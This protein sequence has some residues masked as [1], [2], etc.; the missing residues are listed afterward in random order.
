MAQPHIGVSETEFVR[1]SNN[2]FFLFGDNMDD[3]D[4]ENHV[5]D[6]TITDDNGQAWEDPAAKGVGNNRV[7]IKG[8]PHLIKGHLGGVGD[9]QITITNGSGQSVTFA[10]QATYS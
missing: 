2:T 3:V 9:T 8:K 10:F 1:G 7:R 4:T 5:G 6:L